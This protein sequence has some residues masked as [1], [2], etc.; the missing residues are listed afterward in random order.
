[1]PVP[2]IQPIAAQ[3][4]V[5]PQAPMVVMGGASNPTPPPPPGSIQGEGPTSDFII[6]S[7]CTTSASP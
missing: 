5:P 3:P 1:M 2:T 7:F 6:Y 4:A